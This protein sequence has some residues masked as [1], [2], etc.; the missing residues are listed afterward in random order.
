[1]GALL[2][3][4]NLLAGGS[5]GAGVEGRCCRQGAVK[6]RALRVLG[7]WSVGAVKHEGAIDSICYSCGALL[8]CVDLLTGRLGTCGGCSGHVQS[9]NH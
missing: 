6:L 1:M 7:R 2:A 5:A 3:L 4:G 8:R 9:C